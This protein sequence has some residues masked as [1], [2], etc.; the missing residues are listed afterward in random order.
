[1][2]RG[3][4]GN[5]QLSFKHS[6]LDNCSNNFQTEF[7]YKHTPKKEA[8][9][10]VTLIVNKLKTLGHEAITFTLANSR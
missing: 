7:N 1:M 2:L 3:W 6:D 10:K 8:T 4:L 5:G 9:D